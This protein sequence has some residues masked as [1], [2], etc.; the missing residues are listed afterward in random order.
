MDSNNQGTLKLVERVEEP[1]GL[2]VNLIRTGKKDA[3]DLVALATQINTAQIQIKN[4]AAS[5]LALIAEQIAF[6]QQ[7]AR[8]VLLEAQ[9]DEMLHS[10]GCN[11]QKIPGHIYHLYKNDKSGNYFWSM[12]S[13][14]E[15]G[16]R[17]SHEFIGSFRMES[18]RSFTNLKDIPEYDNKREL[19]TELLDAATNHKN[20]MAIENCLKPKKKEA[21]PDI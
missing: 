18:D 16:S 17:I 3:G 7:Q 12:I 1:L 8:N 6:L 14:E 5:K 2:K 19:V 20:M 21:L 11:F 9:K 4:N 10:A 15:W 13:P